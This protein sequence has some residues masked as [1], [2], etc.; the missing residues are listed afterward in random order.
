M[1]KNVL[2]PLVFLI[3]VIAGVYFSNFYSS[4]TTSVSQKHLEQNSE[5]KSISLDV[6]PSSID[7][8][9]RSFAAFAKAKQLE[10]L[11]DSEEIVQAMNTERVD[12]ANA[13]KDFNIHVKFLP[14]DVEILLCDDRHF[15][16]YRDYHSTSE[17]V[18]FKYFGHDI[19]CECKNSN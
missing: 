19:P 3:L 18:D 1:K 6:T 15:L 13:L 11:K 7:I 12:L 10:K 4:Q 14:S 9:I 17:R 8:Y 2:V 16:R 5:L